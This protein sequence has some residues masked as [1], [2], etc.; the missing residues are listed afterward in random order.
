MTASG[1]E[2]L[3]FNP[4][5]SLYYFTGLEFHLSERPILLI[6]TQSCE[7]G[8]VLPE[9]ELGKVAASILTIKGYTYSD[10]PTSWAN[11]FQWASADMNISGRTIGIEPS[12]LRVLEYRILEN[13]MKE[14]LFVSS[15][16]VISKCRIIKD[17]DEI[18]AMRKAAEIAEK[19]LL[20]LLP[21]QWEGRAEKDIGI[22]AGHPSFGEWFRY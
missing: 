22:R 5:P 18:M 9:L 19:A 12:R 3:V 7:F 11:A 21:G 6:L 13:S 15:E 10:D 2:A 20:Q 17:D 8:I 14:S 16:S 1:I 4:G